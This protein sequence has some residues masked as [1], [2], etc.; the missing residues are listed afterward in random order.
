M[1]KGQRAMAVAMIYPEP[2]KRG[3]GKKGASGKL[4]ET[5]GFSKRRLREARTVLKYSIDGDLADGVLSG[6]LKLDKEYETAKTRK[7]EKS[8]ADQLADLRTRYP[9]LA[10]KVVEEELTLPGAIVAY[11]RMSKDDQL[12]C[13]PNYPLSVLI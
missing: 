3:R 9:D 7:T 4:A 2:D 12:R 1:T 11:A 13:C 10:D 6:A 5:A 8:F